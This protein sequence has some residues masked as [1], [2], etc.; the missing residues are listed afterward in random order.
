MVKRE[1]CRKLQDLLHHWPVLMKFRRY[2]D[3]LGPT[4]LTWG[5]YLVHTSALISNLVFKVFVTDSPWLSQKYNTISLLWYSLDKIFSWGPA[6][7]SLRSTP[8]WWISNQKKVT[9]IWNIK[10]STF[11]STGKNLQLW[12]WYRYVFPNQPETYLLWE[13]KSQKENSLPQ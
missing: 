13:L 2:Q 11:L 10:D 1:L 4:Y 7:S 6:L 3:Q 8:I 12:D 9:Q 5:E